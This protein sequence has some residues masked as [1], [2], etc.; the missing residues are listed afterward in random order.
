[1]NCNATIGAMRR[2]GLSVLL[3]LVVAPVRLDAAEHPAL[4][5]ARMLYN[6]ADFDG[7]IANAELARVDPASKDAADLVGA[8][9]RLER[10]RLHNPDPAD[11]TAAREALSRVQIE[12]L[13]PRDQLDLLIGFGQALYLANTFG[14]AAELFDTALRRAR[15][16]SALSDR[17]RSM[18]LDWWA[19]AVDREAQARGAERR[20]ALMRPVVERMEEE[21]YEDPGNATANYWLAVAV[22]GT[23]DTDRA[24]H[25]AIA[26]W[27]RARMHAAI[28]TTLRSSIDRFVTAVLIPERARTRPARD[29][30][31]A[32]TEFQAEWEQIKQEWP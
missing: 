25:A 13:T 19:N 18:L 4:V 8:R 1:M 12:V 21:L 2:C 5:K 7:A 20:A 26:A 16:L 31:T 27:V 10:Y 14:A 3:L 17:E 32:L 22:L 29:Q 11:L 30:Q 28:S 24:W 9:A 6:A 23:G 15:A